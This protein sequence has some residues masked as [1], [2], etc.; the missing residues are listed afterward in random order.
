MVT[1]PPRVKAFINEADV[2]APGR[3]HDSDSTYVNK[4]GDHNVDSRGI[5]HAADIGQ[6]MP[7]TPYW[8]PKYQEFDV[9]WWQREIARQYIAAT[10][11]VRSSRWPW[12]F[13][14][15][16]MHSYDYARK[17]D[18][19]FTPTV[20]LTWRIDN[21]PPSEHIQHG[22]FSIGHTVR[23]E[24]DTQPIFVSTAVEDDVTPQDKKEIIA[25][26]VAA[27][28]GVEDGKAHGVLAEVVK[29]Y[30]PSIRDAVAD[31]LVHEP[32]DGQHFGRVTKELSRYLTDDAILDGI[33]VAVA[34]RM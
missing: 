9:H 29:H 8:L 1:V 13:D 20:S 23:S 10:P 3:R 31:E 32:Y 26:V 4:P 5:N 17:V 30:I 14:G 16:Y 25:G 22:H 12:L 21:N 28:G 27:L 19:I 24:Q 15:G 18:I 7:G 2:R 6:C 11:V 34:K 33:A